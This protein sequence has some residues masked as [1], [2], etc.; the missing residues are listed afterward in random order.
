MKKKNITDLMNECIL[1]KSKQTNNIQKYSK[2]FNGDITYMQCKNC[3]LIY[4]PETKKYDLRKI[5]NN[6]YFNKTDFGW[7]NRIEWILKYLLLL[8]KTIY[9][10]KYQ[11]C[12]FGAGNGYLTKKLI[13]DGFTV[14]AYEPYRQKTSFLNKKEYKTQP[15][16]TDV[17]LMIEVFE[18]FTDAL[19]ELNKIINDF[20]HPKLI[21]ITTNLTDY[22]TP[23]IN[24]W[25]YLNPA[26]GHFTLWSKKS[27]KL[28]GKI[29]KYRFTSL[30]D[31]IHIFYKDLNKYEQVKLN[32]LSAILR[33]RINLKKT[34]R[35]H[36]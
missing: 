12:D 2:I 32:T 33:M 23:P 16:K 21:I 24:N 1:C 25:D 13:N 28:F 27:L 11:I 3:G 30:T 34:I 31:S 22:A 8:N 36:K 5:Y 19:N 20:H 29:H 18:H 15:F 26:A 35:R 6:T 14:T 10:K 4:A 7:K 9:L 17:L